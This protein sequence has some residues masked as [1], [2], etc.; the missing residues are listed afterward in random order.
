MVF[1]SAAHGGT[2][3]EFFIGFFCICCSKICKFERNIIYLQPETI[4]IEDYGYDIAV[5]PTTA[6][7]IVL[8]LNTS[9]G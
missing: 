5:K 4:K 2:R 8:E 3:D 6:D 1:L 9:F 7:T